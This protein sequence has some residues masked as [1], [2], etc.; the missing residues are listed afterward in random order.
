MGLNLPSLCRTLGLTHRTSYEDTIRADERF[1]AE[2]GLGKAPTTGL[3]DVME[4]EL[5]ILVFI[6][7]LR[8]RLIALGKLRPV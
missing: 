6:S 1:A 4:K 3:D 7:A 2:F 8:W 5:S